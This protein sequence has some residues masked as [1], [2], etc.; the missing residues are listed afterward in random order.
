MGEEELKEAEGKDAELVRLPEEPLD[1]HGAPE[2][3][4]AD[5]RMPP[6]SELTAKLGV[7]TAQAAEDAESESSDSGTDAVLADRFGAP[8]AEEP[9]IPAELREASISSDDR[10]EPEVSV[11][12]QHD[13]ARTDDVPRDSPAMTDASVLGAPLG[14]MDA[15]EPEPGIGHDESVAGHGESFMGHDEPFTGHDEHVVGGGELARHE[16]SVSSESE[17]HVVG[18][19]A[20]PVNQ[21]EDVVDITDADV[22]PADNS[23]ID[24]VP[25]SFEVTATEEI[26]DLKHT[27]SPTDLVWLNEKLVVSA[28]EDGQVVL[29]NMEKL[30]KLFSFYPYGSE[31]VSMLHVLP[32][33]SSDGNVAHLLTLSETSRILKFWRISARKAEL[34]RSMALPPKR[35]STDI[36]VT[37]PLVPNAKNFTTVYSLDDEGELGPEIEPEPVTSSEEDEDVS[38]SSSDVGENENAELEMADMGDVDDRTYSGMQTALEAASM[39]AFNGSDRALVTNGDAGSDR[40]GIIG[41]ELE[42]ANYGKYDPGKAVYGQ[43]A[44]MAPV[45]DNLTSSSSSSSSSSSRSR[46]DVTEPTFAAQ[47]VQGSSVKNLASM[48]GEASKN[49]PIAE[50]KALA[51]PAETV[52]PRGGSVTDRWLNRGND[53]D[54]SNTAG[55]FT[56]KPLKEKSSDAAIPSDTI[57]EPHLGDQVSRGSSVKDLAAAFREP[58]EDRTVTKKAAVAEPAAATGSGGGSVMNRWLNR[59]NEDDDVTTASAIAAK[60]S[61][62]KVT[63]KHSDSVEPAGTGMSRGSSV[64]DRWLNRGSE[65]DMGAP[66]AAAASVSASSRKQS[67]DSSA[68]PTATNSVMNRYARVLSGKSDMSDKADNTNIDNGLSLAGAKSASGEKAAPAAPSSVMSRYANVAEPEQPSIPKTTSAKKASKWGTP[69]ASTKPLAERKEEAPVEVVAAVPAVVVQAPVVIVGAPAVAV[70][71]QQPST[72]AVSGDQVG[73]VDETNYNFKNAFSMFGGK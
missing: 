59:G 25:E 67:G 50:K 23:P 63:P 41:D 14:T 28:G 6:E 2:A 47:T 42:E 72:S 26:F 49:E 70:V 53:E 35:D 39:E 38:I 19:E 34:T 31:T 73:F 4:D 29:W 60:P 68:A 17:S 3:V 69:G 62:D 1:Q 65:D 57:A 13:N 45:G 15:E 27:G 55:V 8:P 43:E 61:G 36:S 58:S 33:P 21:L 22:L 48:F 24:V 51:E 20:E 10:E 7:P 11:A 5:A 16:S 54:A 9:T 12:E 66:A 64:K 44:A 52:A 18:A 32:T 40:D 71:D 46:D 56:A 30:D 37:L